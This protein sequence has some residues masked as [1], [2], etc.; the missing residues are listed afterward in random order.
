MN[1]TQDLS[2]FGHK[3]REE[4][5]ELLSLLNTNKDHSS[6]GDSV[7][8]EFNPHSGYVFLVDEDYNVAMEYDNELH[9]FLSCPECGHEAIEPDFV[10]ESRDVCC[11]E[12]HSDTRS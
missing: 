3:E 7:A 6:L 12:Y 10:S 11:K 4:A 2:K 9:D 1:N 8:V 5:G